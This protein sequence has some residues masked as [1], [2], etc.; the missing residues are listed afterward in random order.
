MFKV[1]FKMAVITILDNNMGGQGGVGFGSLSWQNPW[2]ADRHLPGSRYRTWSTA[3]GSGFTGCWYDVDTIEDFPLL[4]RAVTNKSPVLQ[5]RAIKMPPEVKFQSRRGGRSVSGHHITGTSYTFAIADDIRIPFNSGI[6][7]GA[8][9]VLV[10]CR[11]IKDNSRW[12]I[13]DRVSP[14]QESTSPLAI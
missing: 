9:I 5:S 1:M 11:F 12:C 3:W 4:V 10:L 2:Y 8:N 7:V 14:A 6:G 13:Y